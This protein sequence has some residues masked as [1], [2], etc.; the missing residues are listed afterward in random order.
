MPELTAQ[1]IQL[2]GSGDNVTGLHTN[3]ET[4][5]ENQLEKPTN[6]NKKNAAEIKTSKPVAILNPKTRTSRDS[7]YNSQHG[8][9]D[10]IQNSKLLHENLAVKR[11]HR[12]SSN[13][14][15]SS[16]PNSLNESSSVEVL[17][18]LDD[19]AK[20]ENSLSSFNHFES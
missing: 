6:Y 15:S 14:E 12:L 4:E 16:D 20:F 17:S 3:D 13:N 18:E 5:N 10:H 11:P 7:N 1:D 8:S 9:S 19:E 2:D